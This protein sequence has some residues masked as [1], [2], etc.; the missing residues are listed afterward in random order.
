MMNDQRKT[1]GHGQRTRSSAELAS[2]LT[3]Q[4]VVAQYTTN[5]YVIQPV[6]QAT[7]VGAQRHDLGSRLAAPAT[8]EAAS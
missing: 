3:H 8:R 7:V 1:P 6:A 4:S 5:K 2:W